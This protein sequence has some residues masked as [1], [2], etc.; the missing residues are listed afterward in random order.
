MAARGYSWVPHKSRRVGR[1][2]ALNDPMIKC[3]EFPEPRYIIHREQ[4]PFDSA[5]SAYGSEGAATLTVN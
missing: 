3:H 5:R 2:S 4:G 1:P